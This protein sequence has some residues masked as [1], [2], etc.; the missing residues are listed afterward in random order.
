MKIYFVLYLLNVVKI[1]SFEFGMLKAVLNA[2]SVLFLFVGG[3]L[4]DAYGRKS[5]M[6]ISVLLEAVA[7]CILLLS[8][9]FAQLIIFAFLEGISYIGYASIIPYAAD[10]AP[11]KIRAK[12]LGM[13]NFILMV[14]SAP[15][16]L[17]GGWLYSLSP[18]FP[19]LAFII[20]NIIIFVMGSKLLLK[21]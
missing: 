17:V 8:N 10:R 13:L 11:S 5:V 7:K 20:L 21:R 3:K 19:F 6:L 9:N 16:P 12:T 4:S 14:S 1:S 18:A 15:S 2:S